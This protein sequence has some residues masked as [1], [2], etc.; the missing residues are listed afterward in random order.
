MPSFLSIVVDLDT[1]VFKYSTH[2]FASSISFFDLIKSS[3]I[4]VGSPICWALSIVDSLYFIGVM[5]GDMIRER[6]TISCHCSHL[7]S[8][9]AVQKMKVG[10]PSVI[11]DLTCIPRKV[12]DSTYGCSI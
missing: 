3:C 4:A 8:S 1:E 11:I 2:F 6:L 12:F 5:F 9:F 10:Y 7:D